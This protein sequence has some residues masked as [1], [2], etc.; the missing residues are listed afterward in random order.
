[1]RKKYEDLMQDLNRQSEEYKKQRIEE[2]IE[3]ENFKDDE[4]KKIRRDK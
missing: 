4:K 2:A 3:F 1:M